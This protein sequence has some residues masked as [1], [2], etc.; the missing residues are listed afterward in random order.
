MSHTQLPW[1]AEQTPMI[2]PS[3]D[4]WRVITDDDA[5]EH[6]CIEGIA[7]DDAEFIAHACNSHDELLEALREVESFGPKIPKEYHDIAKQAI[8]RATKMIK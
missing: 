4:H 7:K 8:A 1:Y 6:L 2:V 5:E 3:E